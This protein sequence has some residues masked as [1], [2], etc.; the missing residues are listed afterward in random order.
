MRTQLV[1]LCTSGGSLNWAS[2]A[3]THTQSPVRGDRDVASV[4][5]VRVGRCFA[6]SV[7]PQRGTAVSQAVRIVQLQL[8]AL[9]ACRAAWGRARPPHW[10]HVARS[11]GRALGPDLKAARAQAEALDRVQGGVMMGAVVK[12]AVHAKGGV[13]RKPV[14]MELRHARARSPVCPLRAGHV[15][16]GCAAVPTPKISCACKGC[17]AVV[18]TLH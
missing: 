5:R 1:C 15:L 10:H 11:S 4:W 7:A 12:L 3:R 13:L 2:A 17:C 8:Q 14:R 6:S 18:S 9:H 16:A